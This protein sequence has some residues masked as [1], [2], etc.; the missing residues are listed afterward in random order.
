MSAPLPGP[1]YLRRNGETLEVLIVEER[2]AVGSLLVRVRSLTTGKYADTK[3]QRRK[4]ARAEVQRIVE[5]RL[6]EGYV[7]VEKP[8]EVERPPQANSLAA[9]PGAL[10]P[11]ESRLS[12]VDA[13]TF[14]VERFSEPIDHLLDE[15]KG[16]EEVILHEGDLR[17]EHFS[18]DFPVKCIFVDGDLELTGDL[19]DCEQ[20]ILCVTGSIRCRSVRLRGAFVAEGNLEAAQFIYLNSSN[21][22]AFIVGGSVRARLFIEEGTSSW[23]SKFD[24]PVW[25]FINEVGEGE[26]ENRRRLPRTPLT[27]C[28]RANLTELG[29]DDTAIEDLGE[30]LG[31]D[32]V[33]RGGS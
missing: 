8:V 33:R 28:T 32:D 7:L 30:I 1:F 9:E 19:T 24:C 10:G 17:S 16:V 12:V 21:D 27:T 2:F 5:E 31:L 26:G 6:R 4:R 22:Y 23:A 15:I 18:V 25:S 14:A 3:C 20:S 11:G 29:L 13:R